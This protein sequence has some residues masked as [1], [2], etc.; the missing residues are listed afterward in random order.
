[1]LVLTNDPNTGDEGATSSE[2]HIKKG[3]R[4]AEVEKAEEVVSTTEEESDR[5]SSVEEMVDQKEGPEAASRGGDDNKNEAVASASSV[6]NGSETS[7]KQ[8]KLF[9]PGH[10]AYYRS[11]DDR[12][13]KVTI[14]YYGEYLNR[15]AITLQDGTQLDNIKPS[16]LASLTDLTSKEL[17]K[18]MKE[19]NKRKDS[20]KVESNSNT[21]TA[22]SKS[23]V[24]NNSEDIAKTDEDEK[25]L[26]RGQTVAS[27]ASASEQQSTSQDGANTEITEPAPNTETTTTSNTVQEVK[28][29]Q[30]KTESGGT[31]TVPLYDAGMAV[32]Y[33][34]AA[35]TMRAEI[36]DVHLDDLMEPY[37]SIRLKD[38]REKQTDNA[39]IML[40][41]LNSN[42]GKDV[43][44]EKKGALY[45]EQGKPN[46]GDTS[47]GTQ[48]VDKKKEKAS[49]RER[50]KKGRDHSILRDSLK[51]MVEEQLSQADGASEQDVNDASQHKM[52][53]V[54]SKESPKKT[55]SVGSTT[56]TVFE[57]GDEVLYK[58]S[59]GEE[60][61]AV[62][63]R[64]LRDKK[65]R[66][67]YVIR[68]PEGKEK[69]VY[70]HRLKP[71]V[72]PEN[73]E[74]SLRRSQSRKEN[75]KKSSRG[76]SSSAKV[77]QSSSSGKKETAP[78]TT[79]K[80]FNRSESMD[81]RRSAHSTKS[82]FSRSSSIDSRR[83]TVS[84][85]SRVSNTSRVSSTSGV[86]RDRHGDKKHHRRSSSLTS[87]DIH[88]H[89]DTK[90]GSKSR[91]RVRSHSS[92]RRTKSS[93]SANNDE[94]AAE[95]TKRDESRRRYRRT[96]SE[97]SRQSSSS[98]KNKD[99]S[100][101]ARGRRSRPSATPSVSVNSKTAGEPSE[102]GEDDVA[103]ARS[104]SKL[105][106][107]RKSFA[108]M[109]KGNE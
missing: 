108:A 47:E 3:R 63:V 59:K 71:Y 90:G 75:S 104:L 36:L 82:T 12:I 73:T 24:D 55:D 97:D 103:K 8:Q 16:Q 52:S 25:K 69:Q 100:H 13:L 89:S 54:H 85:S 65:D 72:K 27:V 77:R 106:S 74:E 101:T 20:S 48:D 84:N 105:R 50:R 32:D 79:N 44:N 26:E 19:R 88:D 4:V 43:Q 23:S 41:D 83:T 109:K 22:S 62:I 17:S 61:R 34:N 68:L 80:K 49:C 45:D 39:H 91:N 28:M 81:S 35:G 46:E 99:H 40:I 30:A 9:A 31:K 7:S 96:H 21:P 58:S 2:F 5:C 64:N 15:Y 94:T 6:E 10:Y 42:D 86:S 102:A 29:V 70:G 33:T 14:E 67:Y 51:K 1:M 87:A 37:Y 92:L 76:R 98:S 57:L 66:A 18:L 95:A 107:F 60:S 93:G 38:G 78:T 11:P 56:A 53:E